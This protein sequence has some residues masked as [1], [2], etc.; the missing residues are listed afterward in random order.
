[1][2]KFTRTLLHRHIVSLFLVFTTQRAITFIYK[3]TPWKPA[4]TEKQIKSSTCAWQLQIFSTDILILYLFLCYLTVRSVGIEFPGNHRDNSPVYIFLNMYTR[5]VCSIGI[6]SITMNIH[7]NASKHSGINSFRKNSLMVYWQRLY[8][9]VCSYNS[10]FHF[11]CM[12]LN[13][14]ICSC[15]KSFGRV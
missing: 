2:S 11:S 4:K 1:M 8:T 7:S 9:N 10:I 5:R 15:G 6:N 3:L 12:S 13:I 14:W